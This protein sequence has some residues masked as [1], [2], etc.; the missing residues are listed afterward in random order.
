MNKK[1]TNTPIPFIRRQHM[2]QPDCEAFY[3]NDIRLNTVEQHYHSHYELY[4][5]IEGKVHYIVDGNEY[6]L[7]T[8]DVLLIPPNKIHGPDIISTTEPYCRFV[9]WLDSS[10]FEKFENFNEDIL[11]GMRFSESS[12]NYIYH[13]EYTLYNEIF[14]NLLDLWREYN[15]EHIFKNAT[16]FNHILTILLKIN[17]LIY[18]KH[19]SSVSVPKKELYTLIFEYINRNITSD[20][21]LE[22]I[23]SNFFVSKYYVSHIFKDNLGI[24]LHQYII[25][26]RLHSCRGAIATGEPI[27]TVSEKFGFTDYTSF[28]RAFKKEYGISPKAY[29][30]EVLFNPKNN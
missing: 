22:N 27:T 17:R 3:Y 19:N 8:G 16:M 14:G 11:F 18:E 1:I 7:K 29:Q 28:Y 25:K 15:E 6:D 24:S 2:K 30:K 23:A 13:L 10:F 4:F 21:T 26:R 9:L 12:G 5:F 20:L